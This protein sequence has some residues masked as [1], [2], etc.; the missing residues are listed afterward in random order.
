MNTLKIYQD[1]DAENPRTA[2]DNLGTFAYKHSRYRLGEEE[3]SEP[4][5][6]LEEKLGL[7]N[8]YEY[9]NER[10]E[11]LEQKFYAKF[12]AEPVYI[13]DHS[14]ISLSTSPFGCRWDSGKV[15]YIY[16]ERSKA[17]EEFGWKRIT[18]AREE[19][20]VK[21]L[22]GEIKTQNQY[23]SGDVYWFTI[24]DEEGNTVD[25]CGGFYGDDW[26]SNGIK[27][28]IPK[29]LHTQLENIEVEY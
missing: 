19:Q 4:I 15:G 10:L 20:V 22:Q 25:S 23:V 27:E 3:I 14:G 17:R 26:D 29:E 6:W 7:Q 18:K 1:V 2:W 12:I 13:Y 5:E 16:V 8:K 21:Y 28:Y 24:E 9:S 11:E